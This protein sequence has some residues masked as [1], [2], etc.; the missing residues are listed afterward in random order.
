MDIQDIQSKFGSRYD[1]AIK[2]L[3]E[4]MNRKGF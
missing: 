2:Q 4:H 3:L 1:D